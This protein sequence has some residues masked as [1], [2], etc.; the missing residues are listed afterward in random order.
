MDAAYG[1]DTKVQRLVTG[2]RCEETGCY[3][4]AAWYIITA[5]DSFHWCVKHTVNY[6]DEKEFWE[7][8]TK[9]AEIV[10]RTRA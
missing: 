10:E 9:R 6:M 8:K 2:F 7:L 1:R 3:E 5:N 4:E